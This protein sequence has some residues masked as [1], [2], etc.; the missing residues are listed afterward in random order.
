MTHNELDNLFKDMSKAVAQNPDVK[1]SSAM[2]MGTS[3]RQQSDE[4]GPAPIGARRRVQSGNPTSQ[5]HRF[6]QSLSKRSS[7]LFNQ[8]VSTKGIL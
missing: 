5:K 3:L 4:S 1:K 6:V 7:M 2:V 8:T